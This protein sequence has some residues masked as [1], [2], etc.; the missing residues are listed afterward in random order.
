MKKSIVFG[1]V[2]CFMAVTQS[3]LAGTGLIKVSEHVYA[4]ADIKNTGPAN[5]FGANA[6]VIVTD[7]GLIVVDTLIS[8]KEARRFIADIRAIS[9][10][11]IKYVINTHFHLDHT[12]GNSEFAKLGAAIIAQDSDKEALAK[13]GAETLKNAGSFGL[14]PEDLLGTEIAL[15]SITFSNRMTLDLGGIE[16]QLLYGGPSHSDGS[17]LVILPG[18]KVMFAGDILFTDVHPY[19]ADGNIADWVAALDYMQ[20]LGEITIVPGHGPLS[21]RQDAAD[22]KAYLLTFDQKAKELAAQSGDA[23]KIAAELMAALPKRSRLE[24]AIGANLKA[25]YLPAK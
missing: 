11:P 19:M 24:W 5:S 10:K 9:D 16:V 2:I 6:G 20:S 18:E 13:K 17:I 8:A 23:E 3:A 22:M 15:P 12:F 14:I 7:S 21:G 1:A 4:Y 25:R